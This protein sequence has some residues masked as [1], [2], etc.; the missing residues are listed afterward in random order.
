MSQAEVIDGLQF[1]RA[2]QE[3]RG[4]VGMERLPRLA[5]LQCSTEG[6]E[7]HLRGGRAGNG[8]PCLRLSV[9]GSV[10]LLCQ[11]CL[12]PIRF[13]IAVDVE[14]QLAE[15]MREISEAD[16]DIDRVLASRNMDV[17]WLVEDEVILELPMATRHEQCAQYGDTN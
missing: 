13:P 7:Y 1:A 10:K 3:R 17:A 11:R 14:L 4:V 6:L 2:A 12:D 15:N 9:R 5:Q 16:D 8:K